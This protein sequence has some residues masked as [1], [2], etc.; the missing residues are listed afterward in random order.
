MVVARHKQHAAA[1]HAIVDPMH[2]EIL[3]RLSNCSTAIFAHLS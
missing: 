3:S 2:R 1:F